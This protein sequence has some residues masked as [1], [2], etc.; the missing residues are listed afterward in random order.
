MGEYNWRK[1]REK[2]R[3]DFRKTPKEE[4]PVQT[5]VQTVVVQ[6]PR[7][8]FVAWLIAGL[9]IV[10]LLFGI[11]AV[12]KTI[13]I[14]QNADASSMLAQAAEKNKKAVGLVVL[15][16]VH[17]NGNKL[18]VPIGT[19]WAFEKNRFATNAHVARGLISTIF[20]VKKH[21]ASG[22]LEEI[23]AKNG[24]KTFEELLKKIGQE[25]AEQLAKECFEN[26]EKMIRGFE[27]S[28]QINGAHRLG[29]PVSYV[30]IHRDFGLANT[31]FDPD[32][33]V[34]TIQGEHDCFFPLAGPETLHSLK[35][36]EPVAFLGFPME[37]LDQGNVNIDNPVASMQ[38]G[39][40]V[41]VSDFEMKDAGRDDNLLIRHNLP[42]T[43]G[44]SGSPIFNREGE[45]VALLYAGNVI[46]QVMKDGEID[47]VPSA[48]QINF[49]VR[50]DLLKGMGE[51]V[52]IQTFLKQ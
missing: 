49:A 15:I 34:F 10:L 50:A 29:Y 7:S 39:I 42:S 52:E 8:R 47:R 46:G 41:A 5:P 51:P 24:C 11:L 26:V 27:V 31:K 43:G 30:Q 22:M 13:G 37:K 48:A 33:A 4:Q 44:A 14:G 12:I 23:A 25:K 36:G 32:V 9:L 17:Q 35:S 20:D 6:K 2:Y 28:I 1:E 45:V 18:P 3:P 38:S 21:L 40:V 19:A 16:A